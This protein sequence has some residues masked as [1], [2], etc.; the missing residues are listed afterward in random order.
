MFIIA[1]N[2]LCEMANHIF[3]TF[4]LTIAYLSLLICKNN[5]Y[6][7]AIHL[8]K[9]MLQVAPQ[10]VICLCDVSYYSFMTKTMRKGRH[11]D[12]RKTKG[13]VKKRRVENGKKGGGGD[14]RKE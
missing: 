6:I 4:I 10:L 9:C 2:V 12:K 14:E 11:R 13:N 8:F 1:L 5:L 3:C 7:K